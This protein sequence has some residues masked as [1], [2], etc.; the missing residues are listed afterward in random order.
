MSGVTTASEP[1]WTAPF[2]GLS[3]CSFSKLVTALRREGADPVRKGRPWSL[4]NST[5]HQVVID[6]RLGVLVGW[7]LPGNR[8]DCKAVRGV[9]RE[10]RRGKTMTIADGGCPGTGLVMS[11]HRR[12]GEELPDW[13]QAHDKSHKQVRA[14]P[15]R[16]C[17][18]AT[19]SRPEGD[20]EYPARPLNTEDPGVG[21]DEV[22]AA[23]PHF[24]GMAK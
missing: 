1:S 21:G 7:P 23:E 14:C 5:N 2:T 20:L 8:N 16:R 3:P 9:R 22:P 15:G 11:H 4:P 12:K 13:K 19:G 18:G 10:G 6:T 17:R 24:I